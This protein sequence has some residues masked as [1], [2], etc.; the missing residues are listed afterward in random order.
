MVDLK[1]RTKSKKGKEE[2]DYEEM[3]EIGRREGKLLN[4]SK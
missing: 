2:E 4:R 1:L 3:R